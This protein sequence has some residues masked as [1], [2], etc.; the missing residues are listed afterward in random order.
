MTQPNSSNLLKTISSRLYKLLKPALAS[1]FNKLTHLK[2]TSHNS[3]QSELSVAQ[4][5]SLDYY[6]DQ[7]FEAYY[8]TVEGL[9]NGLDL[10]T[11]LEQIVKCANELVKTQHAFLFLTTE[12]ADELENKYST[13]MFSHDPRYRLKKGQG[14]GGLVWNSG[15]PEKIDNYKEWP[16]RLADLD[17]LNLRA[18]AGLPL[19]SGQE[20]MGV[21]GVAYTEEGRT[22]TAGQMRLLERFANLAALALSNARLFEESQR[23][24]A[25]RIQVEKALRESETKQRALLEAI[26]DIILRVNRE[27]V[28]LDLKADDLSGLIQPPEQLRGRKISEVLPPEL[29]QKHMN[30]LERLFQTGEV[31]LLEYMLELNYTQRN[32]EARMALAGLNEALVIV[33]EITNNKQAEIKIRR[34][35]EFLAALHD[36]ALSLINHLNLNDLLNIIVVRA[37]ALMETPHGFISMLNASQEEITIVVGSGIFKDKT[38][39]DVKYGEGLVGYVWKQGRP[40]VVHDYRH[41]KGRLN[42]PDYDQVKAIIGMPLHSGTQLVGVF[43]LAFLNQER[44]FDESE[45]ELLNRF[46]QLAALAIEN[47]RLFEQISKSEEKYRDVVNNIKEVIFQADEK[48]YLT[49]INPVWTDLLGYSVE[50]AIGTP[51]IE[52]IQEEDRREVLNQLKPVWKGKA[53]VVRQEVRYTTADKRWRWIELYFSAKRDSRGKI[54]GY[55]GRLNDVTVRK[56]A[57]LLERDRSL[58]LEM[59]ARNQPIP[60]I[61]EQIVLMIER[62]WLD[63]GISCSIMLLKQ[64][65]LQNCAAP[66]LPE[67]LMVLFEGLPVLPEATTAGAA[68]ATKKLVITTD[69]AEDP[70]WDYAEGNLRQEALRQGVKACWSNP[71]LANEGEAL[72]IFSVYLHQKVAPGYDELQLMQAAASM[73][74]IAIEQRRL[75]DQLVYQAHH[76]LLTGLPNRLLLQDKL[77][78][79]IVRFQPPIFDQVRSGSLAVLFVDLD[80]FKQINDSLGHNAGDLLLFEVAQRLKDLVQEPDSVIRMGGDEFILLLNLVPDKS[81]LELFALKVLNAVKQPFVVRNHELFVTASIGISMYPQDGTTGEELVRKA[82]IAMFLAK[83]NGRNHFEF[84]NSSAGFGQAYKTGPNRTSNSQ[85]NSSLERLQLESKLHKALERNEFELYYHPQY[86]L[87][88]NQIITYETSNLP[89]A[90]KLTGMEALLRWRHPELGLISP[91]QA[92]YIQ[93]AEDNGLIVPIGKWVLNEA[94]RQNK[95]WQLAGYKP[96]RIG[97]NVSVLQFA[98]P[99][100]VET[101]INALTSNG[102]DPEWLELE[103]TESILLHNSQD[104]EAAQK[105]MELRN[106]GVVIAIDDFGTGYSSLSYLQRLPIDTLKIDQSFVRNIEMYRNHNDNKLPYHGT[107]YSQ[108]PVNDGV[109]VQAITT[110]AHSLGMQVIAEGVETLNQLEFLQKIGCDGVQGYLFSKPLAA[111]EMENL[112]ETTPRV[113]NNY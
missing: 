80:R 33:R 111:P 31:Q 78:K 23:Q 106:L 74:S 60:L 59:V 113:H 8:Q 68:A 38:T 54:T 51:G 83:K 11:V 22:F 75:S 45:I 55:F 17:Y 27:G 108:P 88:P 62:H 43:G 34:Q 100:F 2:E 66:S 92:D 102:L 86:S 94:C 77:Q 107:I 105:L 10:N 97:V 71:I 15:R 48:G 4:P 25:E 6:A 57:Q 39:I 21:L 52:Y 53:D 76:D 103:I 41:W 40:V 85:Y 32:F 18:V 49:F 98:R 65:K 81:Y 44:S 46:A 112:L 50:E 5:P 104:D 20:F 14:I 3:N 89:R 95:A 79:A 56:Q 87:S 64:G 7:Q 47:A 101:V 16:Q 36:T 93:L 82:D 110:V 37:A 13:G 30:C 12:V 29:A 67:S 69:I 63:Q 19:F 96:A 99:D 28:Y 24:L 26:P 1:G 70:G 58:I 42:H 9:L 61:L 109:I 73:A 90:Y 84:Y 35:N 91:G 72:G